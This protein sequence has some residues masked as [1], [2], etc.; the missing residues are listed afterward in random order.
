MNPEIFE[1]DLSIRES[2]LL[3]NK[4]INGEIIKRKRE[5]TAL[6]FP[7]FLPLFDA[8]DKVDQLRDTLENTPYD[9]PETNFKRQQL[10]I[11]YKEALQIVKQE[12]NKVDATS[13]NSRFVLYIDQMDAVKD[14]Y[15]KFVRPSQSQNNI[16][17]N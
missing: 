11:E 3:L 7:E 8:M 12:I 9:N 17:K 4:G 5:V 15:D 16:K 1:P 10:E 6:N 2:T 14:T 13:K